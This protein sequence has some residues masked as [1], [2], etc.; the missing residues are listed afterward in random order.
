MPSAC[1]GLMVEYFTANGLSPPS[2]MTSGRS[3]TAA[4]TRCQRK[5]GQKRQASAF[6]CCSSVV[7]MA[8]LSTWKAS[9]WR[10]MLP[11]WFQDAPQDAESSGRLAT[12]SGEPAVNMAAFGGGELHAVAIAAP[13]DM[14]NLARLEAHCLAH[15]TAQVQAGPG[16]PVP[17]SPGPI[18]APLQPLRLL[19]LPL[20]GSPV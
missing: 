13:R 14:V 6:V 10:G 17:F 5:A 7:R 2:S 12:G 11:K 4:R 9:R 3:S 18:P 16:L 20:A 15:E 19:Y 8:A 1:L